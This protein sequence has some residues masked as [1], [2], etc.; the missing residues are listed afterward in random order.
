[1]SYTRTPSKYGPVVP[2]TFNFISTGS[3]YGV[4]RDGT[5]LN[6]ANRHKQINR[7]LGRLERLGLQEQRRDVQNSWLKPKAHVTKAMLRRRRQKER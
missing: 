2:A 5:V 3:P 1:M 7:I 6:R 4:A